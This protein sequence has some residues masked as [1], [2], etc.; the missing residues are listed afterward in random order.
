MRIRTLNSNIELIFRNV[1]KCSIYMRK[2]VLFG[3]FPN[4]TAFLLPVQ[5]IFKI[6]E[7]L[8][9]ICVQ[10]LNAL[11]LNRH[12]AI[13]KKY[14]FQFFYRGFQTLKLEYSRNR[15][16]RKKNKNSFEIPWPRPE[17]YK[18]P[19]ELEFFKKKVPH[20]NIHV[21]CTFIDI[22]RVIKL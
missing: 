20:P 15:S 18:M 13:L 1:K 16:L 21:W 5:S 2:T 7:K 9:D 19:L 4:F 12:N 22:H 10:C 17:G 3:K 6:F 11:L 8:F 14:I